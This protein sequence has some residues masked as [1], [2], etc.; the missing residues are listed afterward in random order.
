[1]NPNAFCGEL[2]VEPRDFDMYVT[3]MIFRE[4]S[5]AFDVHGRILRGEGAGNRW[6]A[7]GELELE[8]AAPYFSG[9]GYY[10]SKEPELKSRLWLLQHSRHTIGI[11]HI[12]GIW[13]DYEDR[14]GDCS[15]GWLW[16]FWG[17]LHQIMEDLG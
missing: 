15:G 10:H 6:S 13:F 7:C 1:M 16:T 3:R 14:N 9:S 5:V 2:Q 12:A 8:R 4:R 17:E 11:C